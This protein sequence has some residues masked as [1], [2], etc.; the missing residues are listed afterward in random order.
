MYGACDREDYSAPAAAFC[1]GTPRPET[2]WIVDPPI[3]R[4]TRLVRNL[5]KNTPMRS[6]TTT[7]VLALTLAGLVICVVYLVFA[8]GPMSLRAAYLRDVDAGLA[9]ARTTEVITQSDL[10]NLPSLV[11]RYLRMAGVPG[12]PRVRHVRVRMHGRIRSGPDAPWMPFSAEQYNFFDQP[13]RFFYMEARRAFLPVFGYHR[14]TGSEA[15]MRVKVLGLFTVADASGAD[16][17]RAETVTMFNDMCLFAPAALIDAP[18][19][20]EAMGVDRVRASF[21]N[22]GVT[23]RADLEFNDAGELVNFWSDDRRQMPPDGGPMRAIRWSTPVVRGYR[24]FGPMRLLAYG[25]GRWHEP[26]GDYAYVELD[27]N[28]VRYDVAGR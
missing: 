25:E 18:V 22:A 19:V 3:L 15:S 16:M 5:P 23:I 8:R 17:T 9:R 6:G 27:V 2:R 7:L 28:D 20:W 1:A 12:Q 24:T 13:S 21:T 26:A 10:A 11:Q 4:R 14:F